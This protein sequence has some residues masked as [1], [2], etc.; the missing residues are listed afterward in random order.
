[1]IDLKEAEKISRGFIGQG[2]HK[3]IW[4]GLPGHMAKDKVKLILNLVASAVTALP[5][6]GDIEVSMG[7]TVEAPSFVIRCRGTGARPPQYLAEFVSGEQQPQLDA[8]TIQAY[9][10]WRLAH[11]SGMRLAIARDEADVVLSAQ[12]AT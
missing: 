5:R 2:K 1:M 6:G 8:M 12:S 4:Q 7:G 11:A 9:Y 10:T 3:L